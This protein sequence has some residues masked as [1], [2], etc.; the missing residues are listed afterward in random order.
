MAQVEVPKGATQMTTVGIISDTHSLLRPEA[1]EALKA[2]DLIVHAG[3]MGSIE[4]I[5]ALSEIAPGIEAAIDELRFLQDL[6]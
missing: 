6:R 3:D 1:I 4:A 5:D 2:C